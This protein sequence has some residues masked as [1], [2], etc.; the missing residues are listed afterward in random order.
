[1]VTIWLIYIVLSKALLIELYQVHIQTIYTMNHEQK[2]NQ[3]TSSWRKMLK[4]GT[5]PTYIIAHNLAI[6][7]NDV[8]FGVFTEGKAMS[9]FLGDTEIFIDLNHN[10][11][12]CLFCYGSVEIEK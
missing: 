11:V 4:Q 7:N 5:P 8:E 1:M 2:H 3:L 12:E 6:I 9:E 10:Q